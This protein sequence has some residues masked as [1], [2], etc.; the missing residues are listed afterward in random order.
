MAAEIWCSSSCDMKGRP[1]D[2]MELSS[3]AN[4]IRL[5]VIRIRQK[6]DVVCWGC[7]NLNEHA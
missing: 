3:L 2:A 4:I 6:T 5:C 1:L 7:G